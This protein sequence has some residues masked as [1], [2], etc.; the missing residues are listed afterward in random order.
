MLL[1]ADVICKTPEVAVSTACVSTR[2]R[3]P[4]L[5]YLSYNPTQLPRLR[6]QR[7]LVRQSFTMPPK[8]RTAEFHSTLNSIKS[9][10][11]VTS[12]S[13]SSKDRDREAKQRLIP[14][15]DGRPGEAGGSGMSEF[16]RMAGGIAKDINATTLKL[17]KLAQREFTFFPPYPRKYRVSGIPRDMAEAD[18]VC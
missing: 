17:Q 10:T 2:P 3:L 6:L 18:M 5:T 15:E 14:K 4:F 12:S 13:S 16:G 9:R 1:I 11:A 8:D 7:F